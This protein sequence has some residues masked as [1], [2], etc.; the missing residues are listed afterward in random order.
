MFSKNE[1]P[2]GGKGIPSIIGTSMRV[3]GDLDSDGAVQ[4]EGEIDGDVR[5]VE[6]TV[7]PNANVRGQ[8]HAET[9]NIHGNVNGEIRA[10]KVLLSATAHVT[11]DIVHEEVSI[12]AGAFVEGQLLRRDADQSKLNLVVGENA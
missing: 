2:G 1:R 9:A 7:G 8:I 6:V 5:C 11:G 4:I 10:Q 12:E 3:T